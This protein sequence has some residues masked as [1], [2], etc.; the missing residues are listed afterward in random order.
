[1]WMRVGSTAVQAMKANQSAQMSWA[2]T[3]EIRG[4]NDKAT[5]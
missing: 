4:A 2:G 5:W 3:P 1:M